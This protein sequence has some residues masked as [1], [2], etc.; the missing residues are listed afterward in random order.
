MLTRRELIGLAAAIGVGFG[1]ISAPALAATTWDY[2]A[3]TGVTHPITIFLKGFAEEVEKR[4][5]G[6]L[7][8]VVRPAGELPFRATESVKATG[9]GLVQMGSA[10]AGFIS[11]TLP[12]AAISGHPFLVRTYDDLA[13]VWPIMQR[14][15][16]KDFE[17]LGVKVLFYFSWPVQ[18]IFGFGESMRSI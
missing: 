18:T 8:I 16:E 11:G 3:F 12:H 9:Q 5:D 6:E 1:F 15:T 13:K 17:K 7:K 14:N 2:Y 4:T 10:Y